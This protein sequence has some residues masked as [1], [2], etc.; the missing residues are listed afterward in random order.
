MFIANATNMSNYMV[1]PFSPDRLHWWGF[2]QYTFTTTTGSKFEPINPA[3]VLTN[4]ELLNIPLAAAIKY[5]SSVPGFIGSSTFK[6]Q[7]NNTDFVLRLED[8]GIADN[9]GLHTVKSIL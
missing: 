4:H 1:V 6:S 7:K 2:K 8:G 9:F 5:S 3:N